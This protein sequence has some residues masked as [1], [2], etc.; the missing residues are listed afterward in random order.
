MSYFN[1]GA[2]HELAHYAL[3]FENFVTRIEEEP[4]WLMFP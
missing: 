4:M 2:A 3:T 1:N